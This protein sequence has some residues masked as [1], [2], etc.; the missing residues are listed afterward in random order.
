MASYICQSCGREFNGRPSRSNRFCCR[1][2][3]KRDH[4]RV[5]PRDDEETAELRPIV[6]AMGRKL[7]GEMA[8]RFV[9]LFT[10]PDAQRCRTVVYKRVLRKCPDVAPNAVSAAINATLVTEPFWI[11]GD[12]D[13]RPRGAPVVSCSFTPT[14]SE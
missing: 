4:R 5:C 13:T 10:G 1:A 7:A 9:D 6:I 11:R 14:R 8:V 3:I 2:C 12:A